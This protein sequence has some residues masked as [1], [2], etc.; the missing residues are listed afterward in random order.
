MPAANAAVLKRK[1]AEFEQRKQFDRAVALYRQVLDEDQGEED[2]SLYNRVGDMYLRL[3]QIGDAMELFERAVDRYDEAGLYNNAIALCNKILR[4]SPGRVSVYYKLGKVAAKKGFRNDAKVNFLE[5]ASR[6]QKEGDLNEAFRALKEYADLCPDQDDIRQMLAEQ[7]S[8]EGRTAEAVEQLQLLY[9]RYTLEGNAAA[10]TA[11]AERMRALDPSAEPVTSRAADEGATAKAGDLVFLDLDD[12]ATVARKPTPFGG[13]APVPPRGVTPAPPPPIAAAPTPADLPFLE[14]PEPLELSASATIDVPAIPE[15]VPADV[16][17]A[18]VAPAVEPF[19]F[20]PTTLTPSAPPP[21]ADGAERTPSADDLLDEEAGAVLAEYG[22]SIG[23]PVSRLSGGTTVVADEPGEQMLDLLDLEPAPAAEPVSELP[24]VDLGDASSPPATSEAVE[25]QGGLDDLLLPTEPSTQET[26]A[27]LDVA[28][29]GG[30]PLVADEPSTSA[31]ESSPFDDMLIDLG[32]AP[33]EAQETVAPLDLEPTVAE[34]SAAE[35][36]ADIDAPEA[37]F[38][39]TAE[40]SPTA[41]PAAGPVAEPAVEPPPRRRTSVSLARNVVSL[42]TRVDQDPENWDLL[43]TYAEALLDDGERDAGLA[44]LEAAMVGYEKADD[45]IAARS[46]ADEIVRLEPTS[47]RHQQKR[48]EYCFRSGDRG[49]LVDAYVDLADALFKDGQTEKARSVYERVLELAPGEA[50]A[51]AALGAFVHAEEPPAPA[52]PAADAR[53][54]TGAMRTPLAS[55]TMPPPPKPPAD[56]DFIDLGDLLRADEP[57]KNTRMVVEDKEPTG[58]EDADFQDMLRKFKEGVAQNVEEE[59]YDSHYDLGVA[60]KEMGLLDEAIGEFQKALRGTHHRI[61]THEA[62]GQCFIEKGMWPV[63][64]TILQKATMEPALDDAQLIGV[65]YLL[66]QAYEELKKPAD[67]L[68]AYQRVYAVDI[69]FRDVNA[70]VMALS[71][72]LS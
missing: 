18:D 69:G 44:A 38:P 39:A 62:L 3:G 67:A 70:R 45:L 30:P 21:V 42:R 33:G 16:A 55:P 53:R 54:Y 61:R 40:P 64:A 46:V 4:Q 28:F 68:T 11:T 47:I 50:R 48:V 19:G 34:A 9:D 58:D 57:E 59:D 29:S 20:E 43:R 22:E 2:V 41:E 52:A 72:S 10:A 14:M 37:D 1:A 66:G 17:P 36:L 56:D 7:L 25:V 63:A 5:Y 15:E 65:L 12:S 49:G 24:L 6:K 60:F 35:S 51:T 8:R 13:A 31:H 27:L 23:V 71:K 26:A 32:P